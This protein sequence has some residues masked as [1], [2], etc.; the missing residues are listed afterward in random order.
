MK[1]KETAA[2]GLWSFFGVIGKTVL[3]LIWGEMKSVKII[4]YM[5]RFKSRY[6][7]GTVCMLGAIGLDLLAPVLIQKIIDDVV[8]GKRLEILMEL[9]LGLAGIGLGRALLGYVKEFTFDWIGM[10]ATNQM[11]K[12]VFDHIQTLSVDF[13]HQHNTGELMTRIKDDVDKVCVSI[14]FIGMLAVEAAVHTV[15]VVTCMLRLSP[16]LTLVP[17]ALLPVIGVMAVRMEQRLGAVYDEI[18]DET[19]AMNTVAEE[20]LAGVRTVKAFTR[21]EYEMNKFRGHNKRFYDLN[22]KQAGLVAA[23]QPAISFMGKVMLLAVVIVGG[24]L[25]IRGDMTLGTLSAF[26]EYA[27]NII[28]PMEIIGW[29]SNDLGSAMASWKKIKRIMREAPVICD[30]KEPVVLDQVKGQL[31]FD[32]VSLS[33]DGKRILEDISFD[34]Q[35]GKT[36]GIMGMTGAGKSMMVSLTQRFYDPSEGAVLLDGVDL[37]RLSLKQLRSSMAVVAQDVFLFSDTVTQ[38]VRMGRKKTLDEAMVKQALQ[39]A[40]AGKFVSSLSQQENT[41]IGERG[42]GLSGGQ[43]QRIS[44]ARAIAK[45]APILILDDSTSALDMETEEQLQ[46]NLRKAGGAG[47]IIIGHRISAVRDADEILILRDGKIL[48]RGNHEELM[49][50]QGEYYKTW[51]VQYGEGVKVCQ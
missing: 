49:K 42:V 11:R 51:C 10:T 41:L 40:E 14:G 31:T 20:N 9:L 29:L 39:Q 47:K 34:L 16:V 4:T 6:L 27:N 37:R 33:L 28:W 22:M 38:N 5:R 21:E 8:L 46:A 43:K 25:V 2:F 18:S 35:P 13:F 44:I 7:L 17:L 1:I 12:D 50:Q 15:L 24:L 48:E 36:L 32:H 3:I 23:Y 30:P 26:S 45:G 19:A